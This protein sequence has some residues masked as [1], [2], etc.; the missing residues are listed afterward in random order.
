MLTMLFMLASS[1]LWFIHAGQLNIVQV[2]S[3]YVYTTTSKT[4]KFSTSG[5]T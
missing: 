4:Y 3:T 1:T 5:A 2:I